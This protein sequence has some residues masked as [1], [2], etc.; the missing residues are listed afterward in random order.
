MRLSEIRQLK[1]GD[2]VRHTEPD[3]EDAGRTTFGNVVEKN[4][5]AVKISWEDGMFGTLDFEGKNSIHKE[6]ERI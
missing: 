1:V 6:C 3:G 5:H 4:Y 2:Q